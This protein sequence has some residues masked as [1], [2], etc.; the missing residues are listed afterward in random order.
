MLAL[1]VFFAIRDAVAACLPAGQTVALSAPATPE[2]ILRAIQHD[3]APLAAQRLL[4][5]IADGA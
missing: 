2:A 3:A 5:E 1:S 4:E